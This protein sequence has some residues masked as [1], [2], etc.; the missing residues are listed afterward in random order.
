MPI[1]E[2]IFPSFKVDPESLA[3][4]K[5]NQKAMFGTFVGVEGLTK[6]FRGPILEDSGNAVDP[7]AVRSLIAIR[8]SRHRRI[9]VLLLT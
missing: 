7:K 9:M 4:L 6:L 5:E 8:K 3:S 2:L 1:T